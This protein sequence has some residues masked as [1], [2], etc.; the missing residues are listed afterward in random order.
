VRERKRV[1]ERKSEKRKSESERVKLICFAINK[2]YT[3][4]K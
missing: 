4:S 2:I 1:R 3:F